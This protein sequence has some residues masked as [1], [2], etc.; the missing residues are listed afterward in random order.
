[1]KAIT[2]LRC[3][4][5]KNPMGIEAVSPRLSWCMAADERGARQTAYRIE[6][7]S[8]ENLLAVGKADRWDSGRVDSDSSVLIW[9]EGTR[10]RS[11]QKCWWRVHV[12]DE[13][14]VESISESA[15]WEM[16]LL[17]PSDWKA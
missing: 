10:L 11:R 6:V 7:A 5:L 14:G 9:Y 2:E 1:M 15:Y 4:H 16:G 3:E 8:S 13:D 12:W 17:R